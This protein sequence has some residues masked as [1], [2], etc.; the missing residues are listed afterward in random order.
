MVPNICQH[1][2][3]FYVRDGVRRVYSCELD[4]MIVGESDVIREHDV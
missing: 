2:K 4:E 1:D 3:I